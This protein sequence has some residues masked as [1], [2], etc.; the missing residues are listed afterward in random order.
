LPAPGQKDNCSKC[1]TQDKPEQRN[2]AFA[3]NKDQAHE[4]C[5]SCHMEITKAQQPS[6]PVECAGCH[7]A[8]VRA[9]FKKVADVPRLEAGQTD[10]ALLMAAPAKVASEPVL[11]SAV[12]FNHKLHEEKNEN[13]SVCHHNA[14]SKGVVACSQCHTSL[15]KEEGGFVTTEQAMHR[16]TSQASCVGCHTP[17]AG[18]AAV[19]RMP[20]L[21]GHNRS[22]YRCQLRQVSCQYHRRS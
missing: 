6:G 21:H 1:H 4:K 9:G 10:F 12:P 19:R 14:S 13:C 15:G 7:D 2:L 20:H 16:V 17:V 8:T 22:E 5:L 3:E 18:Q 11:M